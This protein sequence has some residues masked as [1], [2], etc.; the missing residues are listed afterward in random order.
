METL[1]TQSVN[2]AVSFLM[3]G[4]VIAVPTETVYGLA[5]NALDPVAV[6]KIFQ[7]KNRPKEDPLIVHVWSID[8]LE[9]LEIEPPLWA[10]RLMRLFWPGPLT[11]LLPKGPV[12]P[13]IVTAGL[14]RVA[15]RAPA[16]PLMRELLQ[17]LPFPLAAPSA[18]P[19]GFTSPT[20][21]AHVMT[22]FRGRIP[23]ILD[24]GPCAVGIE[25]TI[26]GEENGRFVLYRPGAIP[27]EAL[28]EALGQKLFPKSSVG[29]GA[30]F[31]IQTPGQ[32]MRHYAPRKPLLYGWHRVPIESKASLIFYAAADY[33]EHPHIHVL[34]PMGDSQ[35]A[36]YR[37][38]AILHQADAEPS[39]YILVQR[40]PAQ[41]GLG[42]AL[43]D[44]L[45]R[46][47]ARALFTIGHS[48]HAW[49]D[50]LAL[51]KRYEIEVLLDIRKQPYSKY[52]PHF[53][54]AIMQ[55]ALHEAGIIYEWQPNP[56]RLHLAIERLNI[57]HRHIAL[58]C[59]EGEPHRCHRY[60]LSDELTERGFVV[61]HIMPEGRLELHRAPISLP[62]GEKA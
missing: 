16:H 13:D 26:I 8:S 40:I 1:L 23:L 17:A 58:L 48:N 6:G 19:F 11:I 59:A 61:F 46:A 32:Y 54:Q 47:S 33:G 43:H 5:A 50:F 10:E 28:E 4:E 52:S 51:L 18:N 57:E 38:Y 25:S 37:L 7:L 56:K 42:V 9:S 27:A 2:D 41:D 49:T 20:T 34:S 29:A 21:A 39:E 30:S 35:E 36:A 53:S 3:Q 24:G 62:L 15:L 44:R 14:P 45:R 22:Y 55:K 60:R 31:S 12:I